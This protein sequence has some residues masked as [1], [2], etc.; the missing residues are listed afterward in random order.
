ML[1]QQDLFESDKLQL[2]RLE[3]AAIKSSNENVRRGIF[4]RYNEL[5]KMVLDLM[6]RVEKKEK[7]S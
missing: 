2:I 4:K 5:E 3:M 1:I 7:V 6:E